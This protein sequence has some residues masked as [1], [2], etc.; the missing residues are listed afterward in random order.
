M[1]ER[2][3][4]KI[5]V[6][7][8]RFCRDHHGVRRARAFT[9]SVIGRLRLQSAWAAVWHTPAPCLPAS[10][11]GSTLA[12]RTARVRRGTARHFAPI[13]RPARERA[14]ARPP[15]PERRHKRYVASLGTPA[16]SAAG[17]VAITRREAICKAPPEGEQCTCTTQEGTGG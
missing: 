1:W 6:K 15:V 3:G 14:P 11:T 10:P 13:L 5:S 12:V 7:K 2:H 4:V 16:A 9:A 17:L 8:D